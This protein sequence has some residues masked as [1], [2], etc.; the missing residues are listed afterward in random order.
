MQ[1]QHNPHFQH[2]LLGKKTN[3]VAG[4][5]MPIGTANS[6]GENM[7]PNRDLGFI[8]HGAAHSKRKQQRGNQRS[9]KHQGDAIKPY[10][11]VQSPMQH[12]AQAQIPISRR[13]TR[14]TEQTK[15]QVQEELWQWQPTQ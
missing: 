12:V 10:I 2:N 14:K 7:S 1:P 15:P 4:Y 5:L 9:G 8:L 13:P 3:Y 11:I 6:S